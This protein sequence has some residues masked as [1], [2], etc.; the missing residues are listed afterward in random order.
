MRGSAPRCCALLA[1]VLIYHA[2]LYYNTLFCILTRSVVFPHALLYSYTLYCLCFLCFT[3]L[4]SE[5]SYLH[6]WHGW[7]TC[8]TWCTCCTC[9]TCW[10]WLPHAHDC[11][12]HVGQGAEVSL[13]TAFLGL[14]LMCDMSYLH[15]SH[16]SLI[17]LTRLMHECRWMCRGRQMQMQGSIFFGSRMSHV[18]YVTFHMLLF[19]KCA[20]ALHDSFIQQ[21]IDSTDHMSVT[22]TSR[23]VEVSTHSHVWHD[24]YVRVTGLIPLRDMNDPYS[25]ARLQ[26]HF[27]KL[28]AKLETK[29]RRSL[30]IETWQ[31][32][33]TSLSFVL[34]ASDRW[35]AG[36]EYHFQEI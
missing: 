35:G 12:M 33:P 20:I 16:N 22:H 17:C 5:V 36:V 24:S 29:P 27:P 2:L 6:A 31:R 30:F 25:Q 8:W 21:S 23:L 10:T 19:L 4:V 32:R 3:C 28:E 7:C 11:F 13:C 26:W 1:L 15:V 14:V 34:R 18:S 9:C